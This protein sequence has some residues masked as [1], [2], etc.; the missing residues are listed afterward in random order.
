MIQL[1]VIE[2]HPEM[3]Q[4]YYELINSAEDMRCAYSFSNC[5]DAIQ[6]LSTGHHPDIILLDI[7]LP[8]M[9]GIEGI[10]V[11][12]SI[13]PMVKIIIQT[14]YEDSDK[15]FRAI[16]AGAIGYILKQSS[17]EK[18]LEAIRE[19]EAGGSPISARIAV[20][21]LSIFS[22]FH[23]PE[24]NYGLTAREKEILHLLVEGFTNVQISK[25]I[26]LSPHT[27]GTHIK[28]IYSKLQVH[29]R[30]EMVAKA[31]KENLI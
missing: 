6:E 8:G 3:R 12:K 15:I 2:D 4:A 11:M 30:S 13:A 10:T 25:K 17:S 26:F 29:S 22:K 16:C 27:V 28:N 7:G 20:K 14:V 5:E 19:T 31:L 1:W 24:N 18:I 21:V 23:I 9:N